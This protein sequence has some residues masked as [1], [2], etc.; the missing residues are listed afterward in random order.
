[1]KRVRMIAL[2]L[3]AAFALSAIV[4]SAALASRDHFR[5]TNFPVS[6]TIKSGV[7]TM[8]APTAGIKIT[9][10]SDKGSGS[11]VSELLAH[12]ELLFDN[13]TVTK[14]SCSAKI[15]SITTVPLTAIP[16]LV[17]KA[18]A[19]TERALLIKPESGS[20]FAKVEKTECSPA[21]E[22]TGEIA[23]EV[24][25]V[26]KSQTT[27]EVVFKTASEKQTIKKVKVMEGTEGSETE[28]EVKP[29]LE[30]FGATSALEGTE[31]NTFGEAVELT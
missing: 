28:K 18:E 16:V 14:G 27:G 4:A 5:A 29:K 9:C 2:A 7:T 15:A 25:P 22:V 26:G 19:S 21:T 10:E 6:I 17:A 23:G 31:E 8:Y 1:M 11:I 13:C 3:V 30:A 20:G 12:F 24:T